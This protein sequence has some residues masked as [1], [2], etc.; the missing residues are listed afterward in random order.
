MK[1]KRFVAA[2]FI[3]LV[4][5]RVG[6]CLLAQEPTQIAIAV[7]IKEEIETME[8]IL[9]HQDK[10]L[11]RWYTKSDEYKTMIENRNKI[12]A[13]IKN[14]RNI[15]KNSQNFT[16]LAQ[17]IDAAIKARHPDWQA[18]LTLDQVKQRANDR[19]TKWNAMAKDYLKSIN[20]Q[21][22]HFN[23]DRTHRD[24]AFNLLRGK[25]EGETEAI[26]A[27]GGLFDNVNNML[28]RNEQIIQ[29]FMTVYMEFERDEMDER[30]DFGKATLQV[31]STL[32]NYKPATKKCK[33]GFN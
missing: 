7:M 1:I 11:K 28:A 32:K 10:M 8:K 26:Q 9:D 16:H 5:A 19:T 22:S 25:I 27:M 20:Y 24:N 30:Q 13:S 15:L 4:F 18:N 33:L 29:D 6:E 21:T 12:L 31:C 23:D 14:A 17:D 2:L 3:V